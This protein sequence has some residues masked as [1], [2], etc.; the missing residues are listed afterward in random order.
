MSSMNH[1]Q[2]QLQQMQMQRQA[3]ANV[4]S[5]PAS[6]YPAMAGPPSNPG[7]PQYAPQ[8]LVGTAASANLPK[9][10]SNATTAVPGNQPINSPNIRTYLDQTVVPIL[11]D[12]E[13][14]KMR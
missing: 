1:Q 6:G 8:Q 5:N 13:S 2:Q 12:G 11:L 14:F 9:P 4:H 7:V 10:P 3:I